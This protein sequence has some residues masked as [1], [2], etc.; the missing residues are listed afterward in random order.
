M[1][2]HQRGAVKVPKLVG[3]VEPREC[4]DEDLELKGEGDRLSLHAHAL[5]DG[6]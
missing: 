6:S 4:V 2:E 5:L 1:N 3:V